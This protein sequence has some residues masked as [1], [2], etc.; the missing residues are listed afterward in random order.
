MAGY[1]KTFEL[2]VEDI[3]LIENAL[4]DRKRDLSEQ[5]H[6]ERCDDRD[7]VLLCQ[8]TAED[9]RAIHDLLGRIH[10]Q[11]V[12]YRPRSQPYVGG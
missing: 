1:N 10:N 9:V 7:I 5:A 3:E 6:E 8:D 11:K 4:R 2:S 12:F